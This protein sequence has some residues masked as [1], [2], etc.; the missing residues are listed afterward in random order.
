M[1][2]MVDKA[3]EAVT[4]AGERLQVAIEQISKL[5]DEVQEE[6]T[7]Y[8]EISRVLDRAGVGYGADGERWTQLDRVRRL[9]VVRREAL[10]ENARLASAIQRGRLDEWPADPRAEIARLKSENT[11]LS[12]EL[13]VARAQADGADEVL[14]TREAEMAARTEQSLKLQDQVRALTAQVDELKQQADDCWGPFPEK[15]QEIA[16][17]KAAL[18]RV[19]LDMRTAIALRDNAIDRATD[20]EGALSRTI[21]MVESLQKENA[22]LKRSAAAA[23]SNAAQLLA[24]Y[25]K[26]LKERN[27]LE[28]QLRHRAETLEEGIIRQSKNRLATLRTREREAKAKDATINAL[29]QQVVEMAASLR[30]KDRTI[31]ELSMSRDNAQG[32]AI[33]MDEK[34]QAY[35]DRVEQLE[36][37][38]AALRH[39]VDAHGNLLPR[40]RSVQFDMPSTRMAE[41]ESLEEGLSF[42]SP[43]P[44][45]LANNK[46]PKEP[47]FVEVSPE[48][49]I[50]P[51][52]TDSDAPAATLAAR[53]APAPPAVTCSICGMLKEKAKAWSTIWHATVGFSNL[54]MLPKHIGDAI[55]A[56]RER[57]E[58]IECCGTCSAIVLGAGAR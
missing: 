56:A 10:H 1:K 8:E 39:P 17:L 42:R 44:S 24:N 20:A 29:A 55:K 25:Q 13:T 51:E 58:P 12:G 37:E 31:E 35:A 45:P 49:W 43:A 46:V 30:A 11:S 27:K 53:P 54:P 34:A 47:M 18:E 52:S 36:K 16:N 7:E 15:I 41:L 21:S 19:P 40:G 50:A 6:Q 38:I 5:A 33:M 26:T 14:K 9:D 4:G 57:G 23:D 2:Q 3:R 32:S 48:T 22:E 28:E